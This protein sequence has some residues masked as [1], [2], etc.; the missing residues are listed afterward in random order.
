MGTF[1]LSHQTTVHAQAAREALVLNERG[2]FLK[3]VTL[4]PGVIRLSVMKELNKRS[5]SAKT[6]FTWGGGRSWT[7]Q[8]RNRRRGR[9]RNVTNHKQ[10]NSRNF[11]G[12]R[13]LINQISSSMG[14][15][16]GRR[17]GCDGN[18]SQLEG[19]GKQ[20][21]TLATIK[22]TQPLRKHSSIHETPPRGDQSE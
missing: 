19:R 17:A 20:T 16:R 8:S 4:P 1:R 6:L 9:S 18:N 5:S 7:P 15:N 21:E 13:R 11:R 10:L 14:R 22:P 3:A 12:N 2:K